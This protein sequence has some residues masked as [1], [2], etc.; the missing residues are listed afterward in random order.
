MVRLVLCVAVALIVSPAAA[1]TNCAGVDPLSLALCMA[2]GLG[3]IGPA[4]E[5]PPPGMC[6]KREITDEELLEPV[7]LV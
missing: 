4:P 1:R 2:E 7:P 5:S 3:V 6:R